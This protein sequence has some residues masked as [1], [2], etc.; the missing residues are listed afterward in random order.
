MRT[1]LVLEAVAHRL[2]YLGEPAL[3]RL[4][5]AGLRRG[6]R[7]GDVGEAAVQLVLAVVERA[8]RAVEVGEVAGERL[9]GAGR[10]EACAPEDEE[11]DERRA[12]RP[13]AQVVEGDLQGADLDHRRPNSRSM[14]ASLSST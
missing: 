10:A 14:S 9:D 1:A 5:D 12:R 11:E 3:H 2:R 6:L 8:H 13:E 4:G 7:L